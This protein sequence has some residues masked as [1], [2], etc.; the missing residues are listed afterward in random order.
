MIETIKG[1]GRPLTC[2][3]SGA[4]SSVA[5]SPQSA[6]KAPSGGVSVTFTQP[7]SLGLKFSPN[8][9]TGEVQIMGINAGTQAE[10]HTELKPGLTL[11]SVGGTSVAGMPYKQVIETIKGGGRPLTCVFGA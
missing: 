1:G 11:L 2:V 3:F 4:A 8:K 7:G 9:Q 5:V 6:S 10:S